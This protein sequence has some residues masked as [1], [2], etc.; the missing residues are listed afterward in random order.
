MIQQTL[1][2]AEPKLQGVLKVLKGEKVLAHICRECQ[3]GGKEWKTTFS[4]G[5]K[6]R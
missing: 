6:S 5:R 4:L 2:G 1:Y 3:E